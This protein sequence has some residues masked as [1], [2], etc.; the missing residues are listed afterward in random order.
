MKLPFGQEYD[1]SHPPS[2]FS[3]LQQRMQSGNSHKTI[4]IDFEK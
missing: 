4:K 1:P 2:S 3:D